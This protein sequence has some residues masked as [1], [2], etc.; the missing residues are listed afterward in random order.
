MLASVNLHSPLLWATLIGWI[1][2]VV[3]HEFAHGI[4]AYWSGD[5]TIRERGG[6]TLNPL[7]YIDPMM[8]IVLPTV[9]VL[10][11]GIAL[12]GGATY[13]RLDLLRS[14]VWQSLVSLAGP[15]M[16]FL[17]FFACAIPLHP[18]V[19]WLDTSAGPDGWSNAQ[20]VLGA[21]AILQL[22]AVI[23][24]LAPVPPL[25][26]FGIWAPY[27][28]ESTRRR[29]TTPPLSYILFIGFFFLVASSPAV[30]RGIFQ[31]VIPSFLHLLGYRFND[32]R[33]FRTAFNMALNGGT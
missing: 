32:I 19:G 22:I 5:Y 11:G 2:S 14:R 20:I 1:L 25:D 31:Q 8:S 24:N 10:M 29:L 23:L 13:V 7:Q 9:F 27:M 16:N 15:V 33:F 4:V 28:N 3:L 17:L 6:L 12:P 18:S 21:L 26:G 30:Q